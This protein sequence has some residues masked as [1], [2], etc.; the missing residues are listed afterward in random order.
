MCKQLPMC[1]RTLACPSWWM[2][3]MEPISLLVSASVRFCLTCS[4]P[5][6]DHPTPSRAHESS[7]D[8]QV[9]ASD[10]CCR[11]LVSNSR[12]EDCPRVWSS[13]RRAEHSQ[14]PDGAQPSFDAAHGPQRRRIAGRCLERSSRHAPVDKP[15]ISVRKPPYPQSSI[16]Q[17]PIRWAWRPVYCFR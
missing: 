1:V 8:R 10:T 16:A 9:A 2:K 14:D 4:L 3:H 6:G 15:V 12:E 7:S 13:Y 11:L 17:P 5:S